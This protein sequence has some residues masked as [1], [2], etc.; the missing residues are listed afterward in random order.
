M[1][2]REAGLGRG[3]DSFSIIRCLMAPLR[4][5]DAC[6]EVI[7]I[8]NQATSWGSPAHGL[9]RLLDQKAFGQFVSTENPQAVPPPPKLA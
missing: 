8:Y 9:S 5:V 3:E 1:S 4:P 6:A 2:R 7:M